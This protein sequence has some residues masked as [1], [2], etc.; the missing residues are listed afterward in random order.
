PQ[1][2]ARVYVGVQGGEL[3]PDVARAVPVGDAFLVAI[4]LSSHPGPRTRVVLDLTRGDRS[5]LVR[6]GP[7]GIILEVVPEWA[8]EARRSSPAPRALKLPPPGFMP[9]A[10]LQAVQASPELLRA[11]LGPS[12]RSTGL[13]RVDRPPRLEDFLEGRA[14]G[15]GLPVRDFRQREPAD[16]ASVSRPTLAYLAYD[17]ANLYGVF[18]CRDGPGEIRAYLGKRDHIDDSDQ[19]A[20]YLDTSHDR[21]RAYVFAVNPRGIPKD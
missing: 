11:P 21:R 9:E 7:P 12:L 1:G 3:D 19:V 20:L 2:R 15:L 5:V 8:S 14:P 4:G 18:V 6:T 10:E 13:P 16:G 17:A